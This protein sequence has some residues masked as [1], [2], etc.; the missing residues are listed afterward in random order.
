M[1]HQPREYGSRQL[2]QTLDYLAETTPERLYATIAKTSDISDGFLD[3]TCRDMSL[4][5]NTLA[6]WIEVPFGRSQSFETLCYMGIPDLAS[7]AVFFA[8]VKCGYKVLPRSHFNINA[9]TCILM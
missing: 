3:I 5:T 1:A 7:V 9:L 2:H 4:C 8:A 6:N